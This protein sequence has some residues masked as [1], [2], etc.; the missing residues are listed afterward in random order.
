MAEDSLA[1]KCDNSKTYLETLMEY[2]SWL[3]LA[4]TRPSYFSHLVAQA[5]Y[6]RKTA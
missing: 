4:N 5:S 2:R 3:G 1:D 6:L